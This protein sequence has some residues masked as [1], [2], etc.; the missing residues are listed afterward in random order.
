MEIQITIFTELSRVA[1]RDT[2]IVMYSSGKR[3]IG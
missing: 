3:F 2:A 1:N